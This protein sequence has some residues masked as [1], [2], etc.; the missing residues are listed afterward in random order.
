M[1]YI[2][3][4]S[5]ERYFSYLT[6]QKKVNS[7]HEKWNKNGPKYEKNKPVKEINLTAFIVLINN[8]VPCN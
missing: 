8:S 7:N 1:N 4:S 3:R 2:N 6:E 5:I